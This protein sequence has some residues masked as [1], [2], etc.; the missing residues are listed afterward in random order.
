M[1]NNDSEFVCWGRMSRVSCTGETS[2]WF[3]FGWPHFILLLKWRSTGWA[4]TLK[5]WCGNW[6]KLVRTT[7]I[8]LYVLGLKAEL[9]YRN[10]TGKRQQRHHQL[11]FFF[12]FNAC[13]LYGLAFPNFLA[14]MIHQPQKH[15]MGHIYLLYLVIRFLMQEI[16]FFTAR[17]FLREHDFY[18]SVKG[19]SCMMKYSITRKQVIWRLCHSQLSCYP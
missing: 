6:S 15:L 9:E 5:P 7:L 16:A 8:L 12:F 13:S 11:L 14:Q 18:I 19:R 10:Q 17:P 2:L 1:L 4:D 3:H